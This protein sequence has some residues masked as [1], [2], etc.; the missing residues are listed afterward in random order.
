[1][2]VSLHLVEENLLFVIFA[3]G[4][5]ELTQK[6]EDFLADVSHLPLDVALILLDFI[7]VVL[8]ALVVFFFLN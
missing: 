3:L 1:V 4:N 5:Q 8:V 7:N 6:I 2:V